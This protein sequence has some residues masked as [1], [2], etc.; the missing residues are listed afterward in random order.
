M[1]PADAV[2]ARRD[3]VLMLDFLFFHP[4]DPDAPRLYHLAQIGMNLGWNRDCLHL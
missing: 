1:N 2:G 4:D 3:M